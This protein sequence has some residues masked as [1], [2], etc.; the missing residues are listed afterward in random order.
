MNKLYRALCALVGERATIDLCAAFG[1][2]QLY[3][4]KT[5]PDA[6][7]P[8]S[9]RIGQP[10]AILLAHAHGG[11]YLDIPTVTAITRDRRNEQIRAEAAAGA[12]ISALSVQ[13][14]MT[15]RHLYNIIKEH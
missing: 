5:A 15:R 7:H 4:P 6:N 13:H 10:S 11:D 12:T 3:I 8:L 14:G 1:G 9:L 2:R